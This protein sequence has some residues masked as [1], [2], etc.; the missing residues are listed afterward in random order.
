MCARCLAPSS[1]TP[2]PQLSRGGIAQRPA[3]FEWRGAD[4]PRCL[5]IAVSLRG[6]SHDRL[7]VPDGRKVHDG[8]LGGEPRAVVVAPDG[9][10]Q[11]PDD[12]TGEAFE[13][14]ER[15]CTCC[16]VCDWWIGSSRSRMALPGGAGSIT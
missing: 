7:E 3:D 15:Q 16:T 14:G 2:S 13:D 11:G 8:A 6:L 5:S 10:R 1:V 4:R 12:E 9:H